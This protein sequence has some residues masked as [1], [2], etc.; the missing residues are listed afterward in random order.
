VAWKE[1]FFQKIQG[2][3]SKKEIEQQE[4][5]LRNVFYVLPKIIIILVFIIMIWI[6]TSGM[7]V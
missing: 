3:W 6:V 5:S 4:F 2:Y 1:M 7:H